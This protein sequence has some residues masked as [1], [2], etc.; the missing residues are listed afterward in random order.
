MIKADAD[1]MAESLKAGSEASHA[2]RQGD[3]RGDKEGETGAGGP[4][5]AAERGKE[6]RGA[7][8]VQKLR[9]KME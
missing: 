2:K 5:A 9:E 4:R 6:Q 1:D 8:N 7:R 3:A